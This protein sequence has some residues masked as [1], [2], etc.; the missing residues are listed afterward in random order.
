MEK[1]D[2]VSEMVEFRTRNQ[3]NSWD[4]ECGTSKLKLILNSGHGIPDDKLNKV[5]WTKVRVK[6]EHFYFHLKCDMKRF[7]LVVWKSEN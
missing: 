6:Q 7:G 5:E 4:A 3:S 1:A 2:A